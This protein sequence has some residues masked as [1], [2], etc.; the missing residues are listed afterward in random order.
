M[1]EERT[2]REPEQVKP[3]PEVRQPGGLGGEGV[4]GEVAACPTGMADPEQA[5]VTQQPG[6]GGAPGTGSDP[7]G[8][9]P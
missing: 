9:G 3:V 1:G 6:G 2:D 8:D 5:V 4:R 7:E